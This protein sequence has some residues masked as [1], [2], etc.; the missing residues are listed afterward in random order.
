MLFSPL[1]LAVRGITSGLPAILELSN[2]FY[3]RGQGALTHWAMPRNL[4]GLPQPRR[5]GYK[6]SWHLSPFLSR[7]SRCSVFW[8]I[9]QI[10]AAFGWWTS[11]RLALAGMFLLT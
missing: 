9:F 3:V 7:C 6:I 10:P 11:L 4:G 5:D 8:V 2:S 1:K